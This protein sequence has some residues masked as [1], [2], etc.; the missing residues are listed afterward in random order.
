MS[1]NFSEMNE[2]LIK[3]SLS[4]SDLTTLTSHQ[5]DSESSCDEASFIASS[6]SLDELQET[7]IKKSVRFS[8]VQTREFNVVTELVPPECDDC[9]I[10]R[11]SLGWEFTQTEIDIETHMNEVKSERKEKYLSMIQDHINRVQEEKEQEEQKPAK[12]KG[13]KSRVLKPLWK[14]F[15]GAGSRSALVMPSHSYS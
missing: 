2:D 9:D 6:S 8:L 4:T 12:K 14:G 7:S 10:V 15:I 11:K 1:P 13:F 5:S 3:P